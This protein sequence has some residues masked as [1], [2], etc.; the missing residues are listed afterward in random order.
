MSNL[1]RKSK[2]KRH[3][4]GFGLALV[5]SIFLEIRGTGFVKPAAASYQ[6][7]ILAANRLFASKT[8]SQIKCHQCYVHAIIVNWSEPFHC[9]GDQLRTLSMVRRQDY[10]T[11]IIS[12]LAERKILCM[13]SWRAN[14]LGFLIA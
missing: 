8:S 11:I 7:R 5:A 14:L 4:D 12:F 9:P 2:D 3:P 1:L 13:S 10:L 6:P